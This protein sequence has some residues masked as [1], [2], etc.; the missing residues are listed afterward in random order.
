MGVNGAKTN[1]MHVNIVVAWKK[2]T[3]FSPWQSNTI[4]L[5]A[6]IIHNNNYSKCFYKCI[7]DCRKQGCKYHVIGSINL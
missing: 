3:T 5:T 7:I 6:Q 4:N 1:N 2:N